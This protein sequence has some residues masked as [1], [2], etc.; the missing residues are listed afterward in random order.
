MKVLIT[1]TSFQDTP[2]PH[3]DLLAEQDWQLVRQRGPLPEDKMLDLVGDFEGIICGDDAFTRPVLA[4]C[5]PQL[6]CLSKYGIGLDK[7]DLQAATDLKIP[8]CNT[9]GVNH[10]TVA[11]H[12]FGMLLALVRNIPKENGIVHQAQWKRITG[13]ELA[14]KV[15]G[16]L[17]LGRIGKEVAKR[18]MALGMKVL[19]YDI[20][21]SESNDNFL[22]DLNQVFGHEV[23]AEFPPSIIRADSPEAVLTAC[24]YLALHMNLTDENR[25][26]LNARR[27]A[28]MKDGVYIVNPSRGGLISEADMAAACKSGKVAGYA[29]DVVEPEPI[30][31]D[32][33]LIGAENVIL[34]P[35]IGSRTHES[36][37]RQATMAVKNLAAMLSGKPPLHQAN[38][39]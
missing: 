16:I 38:E 35:H 28:T 18:A 24:D 25:E 5:L 8:V 20:F 30:K 7:I 10:T 39:F 37:V 23:F 32:N 3:H 26:F 13:H 27:L 19:A 33:P 2:G 12:A 11:E 14:G 31:P 34:T 9:P 21:W 36:V 1:T 6:K 4:K 29:A 15:L 17:G 22:A